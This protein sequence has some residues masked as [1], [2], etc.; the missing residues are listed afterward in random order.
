VK[1]QL[2]SLLGAI[3]SLASVFGVFAMV[4]SGIPGW[5]QGMLVIALILALFGIVAIGTALAAQWVQLHPRKLSRDELLREG[6][7]FIVGATRRS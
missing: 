7:K 1:G 4:P 6:Q 5:F 3:G 2:L